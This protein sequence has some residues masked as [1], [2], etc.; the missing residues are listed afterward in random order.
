MVLVPLLPWTTVMLAGE[1]ESV[2][3]GAAFTVNATVV[4]AVS[5]PEVPV[6][7]TATGPPTAAVALAVSVNT[8]EPVAGLVAKPAVTPLGKPLAAK[9]TAPVNPPASVTV[10]VLV[11]LL[12]WTTVTLPGEGASVKLGATLTVR[13]TVVV[14]VSAPEVPVTVTVTGPPVVAVLAAV[15]VITLE[16]VVVG[17]GLKLAVT[18]MGRPVADRVTPPLNP[19]A[20]VTVM[21][22]VLLL[23]WVTAK[24]PEAG[25]S[26]KL[27]ARFT[28]SAMVV[29]A[30]SAP[31]VPLMVTVTGPPT[32]AVL[33]A[34]SV[35]TL[36]PVVGLVAKPAVTPLG[37]PLAARVTL[38]LNP[39][40][41]VTVMVSVLL[42]P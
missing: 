25:A 21:P 36:D 20:G 6:M 15:S 28:V 9:V 3:L 10:M 17:L 29:D 5:A 41:G 37:N 32:V 34:V 18:P 42:L 19:F 14:S 8:L 27:G 11:P 22:S 35:S 39:F 40:A 4:E 31:E 30:V 23:P 13:A 2:K 33:V 24:V 26:A 12:P 38:P 1:G 16:P 7:V